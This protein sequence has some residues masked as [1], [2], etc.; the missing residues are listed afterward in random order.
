VLPLP[1]NLGTIVADFN[2]AIEPQERDHAWLAPA[3][4]KEVTV[5]QQGGPKV[6][7]LP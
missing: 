3:G 4:T 1:D 5:R 2:A 6:I 7:Q